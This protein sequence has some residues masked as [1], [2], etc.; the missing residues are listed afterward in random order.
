MFAPCRISKIRMV[1]RNLKDFKRKIRVTLCAHRLHF[2][3]RQGSRPHPSHTVARPT[4]TPRAPRGAE[5]RPASWRLLPGQR[6][7]S[8][9]PD[10]KQHPHPWPGA[11]PSSQPKGPTEFLPLCRL[12]TDRLPCLPGLHPKAGGDHLPISRPDEHRPQFY[13]PS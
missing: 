4:W 11:P 6:A 13:L 7:P 2:C 3:K 12:D 1:F 9:L 5:G 8:P 10:S